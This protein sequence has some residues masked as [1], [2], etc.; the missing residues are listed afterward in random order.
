MA[1][2]R[3]TNPLEFWTRK[4]ISDETLIPTFTNPDHHLAESR[5]NVNSAF[6]KVGFEVV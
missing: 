6:V 3:Q 4:P 1:E 2:L 5:E